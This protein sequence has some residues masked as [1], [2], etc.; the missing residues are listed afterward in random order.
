MSLPKKQLQVLDPFRDITEGPV[1]VLSMV[2]NGNSASSFATFVND[3][4]FSEFVDYSTGIAVLITTFLIHV[5]VL[6]HPYCLARS[7]V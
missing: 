4:F 6:E 7:L 5:P 1:H 3:L 2:D